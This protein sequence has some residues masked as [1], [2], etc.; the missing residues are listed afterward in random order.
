MKIILLGPPG[1][2]KGTQAKL[3]SDE[4]NIPHISTGDIFRKEISKETPHGLEAKKYID[5]GLL[6]PDEITLSIVDDRLAK[7]DC[8]K[9]FLFDGFPRTVRQAEELDIMLSRED[10]EIDAT[11]LIEVDNQLILERMTGR[12]ICPVCGASYHIINNSSKI[13]GICDRCG[14]KLIQRD[15]DSHDTVN[16]RLS[17]YHKQT[18]PL[19]EYYKSKNILFT[20]DGAESINDT[21]NKICATLRREK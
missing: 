2:G 7:E 15:D 1:A 17:V 9:G 20:I 10:V 6:V 18:R 4:F 12:R 13:D 3:I 19:I 16:K 5:K 14:N 8:N 11:I 21:F